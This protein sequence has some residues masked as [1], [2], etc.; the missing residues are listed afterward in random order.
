MGLSVSVF[1]VP[2]KWTC[3]VHCA[4]YDPVSHR[5]AVE[6]ECKRPAKHQLR[7]LLY[8]MFAR[9]VC[10][11]CA[12]WWSDVYVLECSRKKKKII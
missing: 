8:D 3:I 6:G 2:S 5:H 7:L 1:I 12:G 10:V 9:V 11:V 4:A